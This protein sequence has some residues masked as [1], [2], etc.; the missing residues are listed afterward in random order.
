MLIIVPP[1]KKKK[2]PKHRHRNTQ[3]LTKFLG[4]VA[5]LRGHKINYHTGKITRGTKWVSSSGSWCHGGLSFLGH[6]PSP[7]LPG[8]SDTWL[9]FDLILLW[10]PVPLNPNLL[11]CVLSTL[12]LRMCSRLAFPLAYVSSLLCSCHLCPNFPVL[13]GHQSY[14]IRMHPDDLIFTLSRL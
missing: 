12:G 11:I 9:S 6:T 2:I 5:Q 3:C 8:K 14:W 4:T 7:V 1:P 10:G 13:G